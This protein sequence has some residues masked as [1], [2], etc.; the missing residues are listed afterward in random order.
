MNNSD[1]I[2]NYL[3]GLRGIDT[4]Q[5]YQINTDEYL[6]NLMNNN[7]NKILEK[8]TDGKFDHTKFNLV[9]FSTEEYKHLIPLNG[10]YINFKDF[11]INMNTSIIFDVIKL[12]DALKDGGLIFQDNINLQNPKNDKL[13][14]NILRY[15]I[16]FAKEIELY[17]ENLNKLITLDQYE[18]KFGSPSSNSN[19][20][21]LSYFNIFISDNLDLSPIT[22]NIRGDIS[23]MIQK[24]NILLL[25][26]KK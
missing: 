21:K 17:N 6:Q 7:N 1:Y 22:G 4:E 3:S 12:V 18:K 13:N 9:N 24:I 23:D 16:S 26:Y 8:R 5:P 19:D 2:I 10:T 20:A 25:N 11:D 15:A 14:R